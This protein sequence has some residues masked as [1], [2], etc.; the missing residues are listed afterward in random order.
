MPYFPGCQTQSHGFR[1]SF[2]FFFL[3]FKSATVEMTAHSSKISSSLSL[4][5]LVSFVIVRGTA[6][7]CCILEDDITL[8]D[9]IRGRQSDALLGQ[10]ASRAA[11][12]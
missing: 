2:F 8:C 10:A 3:I 6:C 4:S 9:R 11:T 12:L 5:F 1:G 7:C